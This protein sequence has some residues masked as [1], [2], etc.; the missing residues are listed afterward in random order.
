MR[1]V[2]ESPL[3]VRVS[4]GPQKSSLKCLFLMI[5]IHKK[6]SNMK[7]RWCGKELENNLSAGGHVT[8]CKS[9]PNRSKTIEKIGD[10]NRT[11]KVSDETRLKISKSR[12]AYLEKNPDQVP[13]RLYHSTKISRPEKV[14]LDLLNEYKIE[15]WVY[16]APFSIYSL[17][18]A[19]PYL[20]IDIEIDGNT[21]KQEKVKKIDDR[22]DKFLIDN[23][24]KVFRFTAKEVLNNSFD[25]FSSILRLINV[26]PDPS[27][28]LNS[29]K[30]KTHIKKKNL[31]CLEEKIKKETE[32][33]EREE[34]RIKKIEDIKKIILGSDIDKNQWGWKMKLSNKIG[35]KSQKLNGWIK[36]NMP[37]YYKENF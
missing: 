20:K 37:D 6:S 25:V 1:G 32:I 24:W 3:R 18:F 36:K 31:H 4:P 29:E 27:I 26:E 5:Y 9:N 22:R 19:F 15:G 21:H 8:F 34:K 30:I 12:R 10:A 33:K 17:D 2:G 28:I 14:I 13:Y 11:R 23:G 7:C 16:N 35:M